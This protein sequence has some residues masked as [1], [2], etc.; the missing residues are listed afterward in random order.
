MESTESFIGFSQYLQIVKRRWLPALAILG[1]A[2]GLSI[3]IVSQQKPIYEAEGKLL[4]RK[5]NPA[6]SLTE[7]GKE[8]G[9]FGQVAEQSNPL[10]TEIEVIRS[11]E[12]SE[13][14]IKK[15]NLKDEKNQPLKI[16]E[17]QK[18]MTISLIR[19]ADVLTISYKDRDPK[20]AENVVKLFLEIYLEN[21]QKINQEEIVSLRKFIE[22]KLP[23]AEK[24]M[25]QAAA[26][27]SQF[28]EKNNIINLEEEAKS[29]V[30]AVANLEQQINQARSQTIK[31]VTQS[32][33]FQKEL[34]MNSQQALTLTALSQSPAVQE[35]LKEYQQIER[36]L[37]IEQ[38]RFQET[39]PVIT[40]LKMKQASLKKLLQQQIQQVGG[41]H[42]LLPTQTWQIGEVKSKL[43]EEFIKIEAESQ[44]LAAELSSLS[45]AL[46]NYKLR[47]QNLP[48]L[49]KEQRQLERQLKESELA[50]SEL[51]TKLQQI[52][53]T[54]V[55]RVGNARIIQNP[56][57]P[58]D[59]L[60]SRK[61][62]FVVTGTLLGCLLAIS[63]AIFLESQDKSIKTIE[64]AKALFKFTLLG[65]IPYSKM[66]EKMTD[67]DSLRSS[68]SAGKDAADALRNLKRSSQQ[69]F[70]KDIPYTNISAAYQMLQANLRFLRSDKELKVIVVSSSLP[71]EGKSTVAANLA[72]AV[73]QLGRKVLLVDADMHSPSQQRIW[74]LPNHI[75]LSNAIVGQTEIGAAITKVMDN[76]DIIT[77]GV[78]PPNPIALLD[79]QR[80]TFLLH[81]FA[82]HYNLVIIDTPALNVAADALILAKK[83]DGL[84]LVV[85]P[86]VL[87][88]ESATFAKELLEKSSQQVL[89]MV[90]NGVVSKNDSHGSYYFTLGG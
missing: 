4:F 63:T 10:T 11:V 52:R 38:N 82:A 49:E 51:Q 22:K 47:L 48:R 57:L 61:S 29:A 18:K 87:D 46:A 71:Q 32:Q 27:L 88:Y 55:Q 8:I 77:C 76:L 16:K 62:L 19:A 84:L 58:Q 44:G 15:L 21:N 70:V 45:N 54:E 73:A 42:Q 30:I 75:G 23:L 83:V 13:K 24:S 89:G 1:S 26:E 86:G 67:R 60:P 7:F 2:I 78:I 12:F 34:R 66:V 41:S 17:F 39:S 56:T 6:S 90:V 65:V 43:T 36:Q 79:S 59:P 5:T 33:T 31:A 40:E 28:K 74:E 53:L 72:L 80:I 37:A 3:W 85:R 50:Y 35:A 14:A 25:R 20:I 9:Q 69:V 68:S 81:N 64:E